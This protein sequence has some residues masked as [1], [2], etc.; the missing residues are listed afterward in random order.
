MAGKSKKPLTV[1]IQLLAIAFLSSCAINNEQVPFTNQISKF[2]KCEGETIIRESRVME[3]KNIETQIEK[4]KSLRQELGAELPTGS[5]RILLFVIGGHF[6]TNTIS[7]VLTKSANGTWQSDKVGKSQVWIRNVEPK[8]FPRIVESVSE[9]KGA[10]LDA[11][12]KSR[13][14]LASP[15][16]YEAI[17]IHHHAMRYFLEIETPNRAD[18]Y[19]WVGNAPPTLQAVA[20]IVQGH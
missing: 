3:W 10:N 13:C 18:R 12:L 1:L 4:H 11:I 19:T 15:T 9:N 16:E 17:S 5:N 8:I 7:I 20:N 14:L 6:E 2:R